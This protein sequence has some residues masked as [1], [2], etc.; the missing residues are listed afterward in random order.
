MEIGSHTRRFSDGQ[1]FFFAI[2]IFFV[3]CPCKGFTLLYSFSFRAFF[4]SPPIY[5]SLSYSLL[6][7]SLS[8]FL[9][10]S[11]LSSAVPIFATILLQ[12]KTPHNR[13]KTLRRKTNAF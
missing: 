1:N 9:S 4:F 10:L 11:L 8:L 7:L 6:S 13:R 12:K 2:L 3:R 5:L